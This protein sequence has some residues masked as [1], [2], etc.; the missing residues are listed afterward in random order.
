VSERLQKLLSARGVASR[1][2]AEIM[3]RAGRVRVNGAA[4]S[5]GMS[6][7]PSDRITIDGKLLPTA[8]K[9][10]YILLHK[11]RGYVTTLSDE[12]GRPT[13]AQLVSA[14]GERVYP[15]G[16][17]DCDSEGLLLLTNDGALTQRMTHPSQEVEKVY[18]VRLRGY[19]DEGLERLRQPMMLDGY[20][21]YPAKAELLAS[22]EEGGTAVLRMTIH[23]G[24]N[25]QVRRM[26]AAVGM[27]VIRLRRVAEG[28]LKLGDLQPGKWRELTAAERRALGV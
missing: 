15:V 18:Q 16:R 25:R 27:E 4:A 11:P 7:E 19:T 8:P 22:P 26:C 23:E 9:L 1:R 13:V 21:L 2:A 12:R 10:R 28:P 5:L 14:C 6:V 3:I 20:R 17:L 24:R